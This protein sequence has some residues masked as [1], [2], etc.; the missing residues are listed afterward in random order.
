M[1]AIN[2][3]TRWKIMQGR[4]PNKLKMRLTNASQ[5]AKE[6]MHIINLFLFLMA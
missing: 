3:E 5:P 4:P 6:A 2:K 1:G